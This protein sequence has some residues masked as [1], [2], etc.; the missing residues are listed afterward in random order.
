MDVCIHF[1]VGHFD[2][3]QH[4]GKNRWRQNVAVGVGQRVLNEAVADEAS[5]DEGVKGIAVQLLK[6]GLGNKSVQAQAAGV[7]RQSAVFILFLFLAPP[8]R[9][10]GKSNVGERHFGGYRDEL[11]KNVLAENLV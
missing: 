10:L 8:G 9:R 5:I 6:L 3:Q 11:I 1:G 7:C 4:H 2:E